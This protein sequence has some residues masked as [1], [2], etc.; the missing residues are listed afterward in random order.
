MTPANVIAF[1]DFR[2][3]IQEIRTL[4]QE[5]Q[6]QALKYKLFVAFERAADFQTR[7]IAAERNL[8]QYAALVREHQVAATDAFPK[9]ATSDAH[10]DC[11]TRQLRSEV[12]SLLEQRET[13]SQLCTSLVQILEHY[14]CDEVAPEGLDA[15]ADTLSLPLPLAAAPQ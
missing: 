5:Q 4:P 3:A 14:A 13:L 1:F 6:V 15:F 11:D 7:A 2:A 10:Q 12:Q 8:E 9:P